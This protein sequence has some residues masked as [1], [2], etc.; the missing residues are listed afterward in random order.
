MKSIPFFVVTLIVAAMASF[1]PTLQAQ[2]PSAPAEANSPQP[3]KFNPEEVLLVAHIRADRLFNT[4]YMEG[5]PVEVITAFG[6]KYGGVDPMKFTSLTFVLTFPVEMSEEPKLLAIVKTA[7][8]LHEETFFAGIDEIA[9]HVIPQEDVA[10]AAPQLRGKV[11]LDNRLP[12]PV[13]ASHLIDEHT[14][15]VGDE[16]FVV[17]VVQEGAVEKVAVL[18]QQFATVPE[19][20]DLA[21]VVKLAPIRQKIEKF[22]FPFPKKFEQAPYDA[23]SVSVQLSLVDR[24]QANL[25]I[26]A[27]DEAASKRLEKLLLSILD[28]GKQSLFNSVH[29]MQASDD[30]LTVAMG[31][32]QQRILTTWFQTL[33]PTREGKKLHLQLPPEGADTTEQHAILTGAITALLIPALDRTREA[34]QHVRSQIN[35]RLITTAMLQY[36]ITFGALPAQA[37]TDD[38]G[39]KLL[40]WRVHLLPYLDEEELYDQFH[41]DEPWDSEHNKKLIS[42]MP[43]TYRD[44]SSKAPKFYTTYLVPLGKDMAFEQPTKET[45]AKSP[46]G[47]KFASFTDGIDQTIMLVNAE[48]EAAVPWTKPADLEV[49]RSDAWKHL[50]NVRIFALQVGYADGAQDFISPKQSNEFILSLLLR[51]DGQSSTE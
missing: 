25:Q 51:N 37:S 44:P 50:R 6:Q 9:E 5:Q 40:S 10:K 7:E 36:S 14:F 39:K 27:V 18:T 11:F 34:A 24:I 23:E 41:L 47:L 32:Y 45:Q 16:R 49:D 43:A 31:K 21:A 30:K 13:L 4:K 19:H 2:A 8:T 15:L 22:G 3:F 20:V 46:L 35:M 28:E 38:N 33:I 17:P 42:Q 48:D 12:I 29:E 1:C 26:E